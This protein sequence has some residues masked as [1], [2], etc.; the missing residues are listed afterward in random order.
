MALDL[1][2][3]PDNLDLL[4]RRDLVALCDG[5]GL[6]VRTSETAADLRERLVEH[7]ADAARREAARARYLREEAYR[8]RIP[9][10]QANPTLD[11]L[12]AGLWG[13]ANL[14]YRLDRETD[15]ATALYGVLPTLAAYANGKGDVT[16]EEARS[17]VTE[18]EEALRRHARHVEEASGHIEWHLGDVSRIQQRHAESARAKRD[19]ENERL[20]REVEAHKAA[21]EAASAK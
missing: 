16:P 18:L 15:V 19:A 13:V 10:P 14:A 21:R 11:A 20:R 7:Y 3:L 17:A 4:P 8:K 12:K 9:A 2:A 6:L 1:P 5:L